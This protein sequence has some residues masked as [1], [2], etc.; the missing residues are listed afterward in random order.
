MQMV[1]GGIS[2]SISD[3]EQWESNYGWII[4]ANYHQRQKLFILKS[5]YTAG[6]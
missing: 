6:G 4:S 3:T 1:T 2:D 5:Q